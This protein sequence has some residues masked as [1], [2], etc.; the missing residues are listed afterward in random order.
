[1]QPGGL[2]ASH[3][4]QPRAPQGLTRAEWGR[5]CR[6]P[7]GTRPAAPQEPSAG[8]P[9]RCS[10]DQAAA[11]RPVRARPPAGAPV[12]GAPVQV[13]GRWGGGRARVAQ[14]PAP[15]FPPRPVVKP[16]SSPSHV[17]GDSGPGGD[18]ARRHLLFFS[19]HPGWVVAARGCQSRALARCTA[20]EGKG[21]R[22]QEA[23]QE[24]GAGQPG[25]RSPARKGTFRSQGF[26]TS[27]ASDT[28]DSCP[29]QKNLVT[30]PPPFSRSA[31]RI[32]AWALTCRARAGRRGR[33][34][35]GVRSPQGRQALYSP[36]VGGSDAVGGGA[37]RTPARRRLVCSWQ[38]ACNRINRQPR[39]CPPP[40]PPLQPQHA[41]SE[42]Q[43][44]T[45]SNRTATSVICLLVYF[46]LP[47][48]TCK[49]CFTLCTA[50]PARAAHK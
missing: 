23:A 34:A 29:G 10:R 6:S 2:S 48:T 27:S 3:K 31:P 47:P 20:R 13:A 7:D 50:F 45:N 40:G 46:S 28:P 41:E 36:R 9:A 38:S 26:E 42:T 4:S 32:A 1:M 18:S 11:P 8:R 17:R 49:V 21:A 16:V 37:R 24:K 19:G 44:G 15:D 43:V 30:G 14:V 25:I 22:P 5:P 12:K 33:A 39:P 35:A